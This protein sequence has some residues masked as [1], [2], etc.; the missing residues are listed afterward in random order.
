MSLDLS[1]I[2]TGD[3]TTADDMLLFSESNSRF[4]V[5]IE[6]QHQQAYEAHM[7]GV[8]I[9]CLGSVTATPDFV[10]NGTAGHRIVATSIN[11]LKSAWQAPLRS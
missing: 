3:E 11:T 10:I 7:T 4:L 2:P 6:P 8:P 9:G 5:E 1:N